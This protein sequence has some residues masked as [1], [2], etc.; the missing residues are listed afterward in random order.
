M[1]CMIISLLVKCS[2]HIIFFQPRNCGC[3]QVPYC[4]IRWCCGWPI[5]YDISEWS[6]YPPPKPTRHCWDYVRLAWE[7]CGEDGTLTTIVLES[8]TGYLMVW[9]HSSFFPVTGDLRSHS[10]THASRH[11]MTE[12]TWSPC[13]GFG[14]NLVLI[15]FLFFLK[16]Y[17]KMYFVFCNNMVTS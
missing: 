14:I 7:W 6:S 3:S 10:L 11:W 15:K 16:F 9:I 12:L 4:S 13:Q 17:Y 5:K 1:L 2:D 8:L